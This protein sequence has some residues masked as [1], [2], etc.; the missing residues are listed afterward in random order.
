MTKPTKND[1]EEE[2]PEWDFVIDMRIDRMAHGYTPYVSPPPADAK[3][4]LGAVAI[5]PGAKPALENAGVEPA[6]LLSRHAS[7]DWGRVC[8]EDAE[9]NELS[10]V[11]G[12]RILSAYNLTQTVVV[13]IIT[14][15]DRHMTTI[16]LPDEY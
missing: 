9:Q 11:H 3:F 8:E 6:D 2:S 12:M 4:P 7:G 14:E 16:L 5:T 13:W 10:V 15:A 1:Q